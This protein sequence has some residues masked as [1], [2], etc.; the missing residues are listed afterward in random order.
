MGC[1]EGVCVTLKEGHVGV[2]Q[3]VPSQASWATE[4]GPV[5][6]C[7]CVLGSRLSGFCFPGKLS[8][9]CSNMV[10]YVGQ[11]RSASLLP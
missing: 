11:D 3:N 7:D 10:N 6:L 8:L 9:Y 4:L 5:V 1:K 2:V